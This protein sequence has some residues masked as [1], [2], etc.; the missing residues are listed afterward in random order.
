MRQKKTTIGFVVFAACLACLFVFVVFFNCGAL[1]SLPSYY[2]DSS[3]GLLKQQVQGR[4]ATSHSLAHKIRRRNGLFYRT[5]GLFR[6]K[7]TDSFLSLNNALSF[8][9]GS[10]HNLER[11]LQVSLLL[12]LLEHSTIKAHSMASWG[13]LGGP[14][15]LFSVSFFY[16]FFIIPSSIYFMF[17]LLSLYSNLFDCQCVLTVQSILYS[18]LPGSTFY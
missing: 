2:T 13:I 16:L 11:L 7:Q 6:Q 12:Q 15:N 17:C 5:T 18:G 4:S 14:L 8:Y 1:R 9:S 3:C 10:N